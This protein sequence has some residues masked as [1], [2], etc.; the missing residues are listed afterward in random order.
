MRWQNL[1]FEDNR[2]MCIKRNKWNNF[3]TNLASPYL[4]IFTKF[5]ILKKLIQQLVK[6]SHIL[7]EYF[8]F[9]AWVHIQRTH[10][11]MIWAHTHTYI[12]IYASSK[13]CYIWFEFLSRFL[14]LNCIVHTTFLQE[15]KCVCVYIDLKSLL[16]QLCVSRSV[17][18][19]VFILNVM[20]I[21]SS[22]TSVKT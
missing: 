2:S 3:V 19:L 12:Y 4:P 16:V 18:V 17:Q 14:L 22:V 9:R 10:R 7:T 20:R 6:S 5:K 8:I 1:T 13:G 21:G 15:F 11:L